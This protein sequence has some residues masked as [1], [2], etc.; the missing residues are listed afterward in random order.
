[1]SLPDLF[2]RLLPDAF[3]GPK[4]WSLFQKLGYSSSKVLVDC[5]VEVNQNDKAM[6]SLIGRSDG[7][8]CDRERHL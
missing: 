2:G 3:L 4:L 8:S 5:M 7:E 6:L 1:M